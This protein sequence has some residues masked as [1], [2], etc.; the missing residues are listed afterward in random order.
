MNNLKR[1]RAD[2]Q[3]CKILCHVRTQNLLTMKSK[4]LSAFPTLQQTGFV[5]PKYILYCTVKFRFYGSPFYVRIYLILCIF[6]GKPIFY[7][8][9][10]FYFTYFEMIEDSILR[11][12]SW[13]NGCFQLEILPKMDFLTKKSI[14]KKITA[15]TCVYFLF[16]LAFFLKLSK[17]PKYNLTS[18]FP[19]GQNFYHIS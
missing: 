9:R 7:F 8:I 19:P 14:V 11:I 12:F 10:S 2:C 6:P 3:S 1:Q 17:L 16:K 13:K 15:K 4:Q 18:S 5:L